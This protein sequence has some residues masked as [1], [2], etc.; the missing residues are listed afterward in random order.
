[1]FVLMVGGMCFIGFGWIPYVGSLIAYFNNV[2][3]N[4]IFF[5]ADFFASV[6]F[7]HFNI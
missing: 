1:M 2:L 5:L 3:A 6:K 4:I 7:G